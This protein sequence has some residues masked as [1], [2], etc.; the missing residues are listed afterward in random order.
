MN[1]LIFRLVALAVLIW[2]QIVH[3]QVHAPASVQPGDHVVVT[4]FGSDRIAAVA[5]LRVDG[6]VVAEAPSFAIAL[7]PQA[8]LSCVILGVATTVAPG[9]YLLELRSDTGESLLNRRL[10]IVSREFRRE[11]IPLSMTLTELRERRDPQK[12]AEALHLQAIVGEFN[13]ESIY[14]PGPFG[15]PFPLTRRTSLFGDRRTYLYADGERASTIHLGLDLASPTG[16]PVATSG[17]GLIRIARNRIIT[18]NTIVI[19]HLPGVFS[20]YYHLD[21]ITVLEGDVVRIGD[22]IG[23]VG[24]TGLATGPHLHWEFR[25]GGVSV[26]P[27]RMLPGLL[28]DFDR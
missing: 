8:K 10:S 9:E 3:A 18:G 1:K 27:E 2:P 15:W 28:V 26:D 21:E 14:H 19:E 6:S 11:E 7:S 4:M 25:V 17:S 5:I 16:T 22:L 12:T 24:A 23:T 13:P 20:L